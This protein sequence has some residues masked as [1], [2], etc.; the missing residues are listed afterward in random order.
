MVNGHAAPDRR[1]SRPAGHP[2]PR[3]LRQRLCEQLRPEPVQPA[4]APTGHG[5]VQRGPQPGPAT[6]GHLRTRG[7]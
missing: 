6:C 5:L 4:A 1:A 7:A 2:C 3:G